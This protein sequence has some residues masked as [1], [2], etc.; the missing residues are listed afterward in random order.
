MSRTRLAAVPAALLTTAAL[1]AGAQAATPAFAPYASYP[2]GSGSGPGPAPV[3][4]VAADFTGDGRPDVATTNNFGQGPVLVVRNTGAGAFGPATSVPGSTGVQ[5]LAAGDL[6][7]DGRQDLVGMTGSA[8]LVLLGDGHGGFTVSASH[9]A[10]IGGQVQAIITQLDGD[11][12]PDIAAMTFTGIQ[13]LLNNGNGT[14]RTGPTTTVQGAA[15]LSAIRAAT[16]DRDGIRD[17]YAVDGFSGT[18]FAL[19]GTG[20]G[21]FTTAGRLFATGLVPEDVDAP[22]LDGDG[23]DDVA[24]IGSFSFTVS[25]ALADG[26]G[27]FSTGLVPSYQSGGAGPTSIGS[28]DLDRDGRQDLV[29]SEVAN[30]AAPSVLVLQGTGTATPRA[31][32]EFAVGAFPQNPAIADFD[33]DGRADVAVAGPGSLSV[34]LN[35]TP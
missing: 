20:T 4:T 14:F 25:T 1:A 9:P 11:G 19:R 13:T 34:L 35:R 23:I 22:D 27:G 31:A 5:S 3:T 30:P 29:V 26:R 12:R 24:V 32:G 6:N 18:V 15:V 21:T 17:L 2:T 28:A 16:I 33:G 7:G 8:V 10:T